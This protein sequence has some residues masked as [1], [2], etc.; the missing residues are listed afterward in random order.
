MA[1]SGPALDHPA[2]ALLLELATLGCSLDMGDQWTQEMLEAA[3][4][5]GAHPSV[6]VPEAA[7]QLRE[8]TLEKV[9]QGYARLVRWSD[10]KNNPPPNLKI[11]QKL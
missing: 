7:E 2:A 10:I 11:H 1:P 4:H 3:L 6:M 8:E 9:A 5:K